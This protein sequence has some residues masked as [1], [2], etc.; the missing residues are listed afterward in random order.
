MNEE[1]QDL[2]CEKLKIDEEEYWE[3]IKG[4]SI[5]ALEKPSIIEELE[6]YYVVKRENILSEETIEVI[7]RFAGLDKPEE[8][9][10]GEQFYAN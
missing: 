8:I 2:V 7:K 3:F 4:I 6:Y 5:N 1:L 9:E 10:E